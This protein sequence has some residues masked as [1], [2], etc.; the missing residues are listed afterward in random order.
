MAKFYRITESQLKTILKSTIEEQSTVQ[1][2]NQMSYAQIIKFVENLQKIASGLYNGI[3]ITKKLNILEKDLN[4]LKGKCY[5][6]KT[7]NKHYTSYQAFDSFYKK[8]FNSTLLKDL[9]EV[10]RRHTPAATVYNSS[11][12]I[13]DRT[14][15]LVA[16]INELSSAE[17]ISMCSGK[18]TVDDSPKVN[19]GTKVKKVK[20]GSKYTPC[21]DFPFK[22]F[23][24]SEI[25]RQIQGAIMM[26]QKHQTGN[27]GPITLNSLKSFLQKNNFTPEDYVGL[28]MNPPE[29]S[30]ELYDAI[31][32]FKKNEEG[33]DTIQTPKT[34]GVTV[35]SSSVPKA[36][37]IK[38]PQLSEN[39]DEIKNM[40]KR[41]L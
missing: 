5:V 12:K 8:R 38:M 16:L 13:I 41:I 6:D 32:R 40:I 14:K 36:S 1:T 25:I 3:N 31:I 17:A 37:D 20:K 11:K 18:K 15:I 23:C 26:P 10:I 35:D 9:N 4:R 29:I 24:K 2:I 21:T 28:S 22:Q 27:F 30:R 19:N 34:P 7:N 33:S 39:I